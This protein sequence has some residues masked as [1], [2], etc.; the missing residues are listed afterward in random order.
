[1]N[2]KNNASKRIMEIH[3]EIALQYWDQLLDIQS[4]LL[5]STEL[6][7]F[8]NS[9]EWGTAY[10]ILDA[11]CGNGNYVNNLSKHFP[12]KK[13]HGVDISSHLITIARD[14]YSNSNIKFFNNNFSDFT[15]ENSLD[16][17][18][19]RFVVQHM[20]GIQDVL[21]HASRLLKTG[22]SFIII[23]PDI[24]AIYTS[25]KI[26]LFQDF[27]H[28]IELHNKKVGTN[29]ASLKKLREEYKNA[30][31][32]ELLN[33]VTILSSH[34]GPFNNHSL[35]TMFQLWVDIYENT[36]AFEFSYKELKQA[37]K[38]WSNLPISYAQLGLNIT[39]LKLKD[40]TTLAY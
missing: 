37:L 32:W 30:K 17:I 39:Q 31:N 20:S 27:L 40:A 6:Q 3:N 24:D 14:K 36:A 7:F 16:C 26:P 2:D 34:T 13:Y 10:K 22:G 19:M 1:M 15:T 35:L 4:E 33:D 28:K 5:F 12:E 11:G 23:E 9:K 8:F 21:F 29:R 25:P 38:D 18:L